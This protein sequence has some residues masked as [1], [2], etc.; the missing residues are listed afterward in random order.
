ML[1]YNATIG[2]EALFG[3][4]VRIVIPTSTLK[5]R[6]DKLPAS[7]GFRKHLICTGIVGRKLGVARI[8][9]WPKN[10]CHSHILAAARQRGRGRK[11]DEVRSQKTED[12]SEK[13]EVRV[14]LCFPV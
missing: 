10:G 5:L 3:D 4:G 7:V 13:S 12:G 8:K 6:H 11:K 2:E 14:K 9:R 1:N